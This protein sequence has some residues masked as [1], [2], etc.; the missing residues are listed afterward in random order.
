MGGVEEDF[1]NFPNSVKN[2]VFSHFFPFW[3]LPLIRSLQRITKWCE[4]SILA[5]VSRSIMI[6]TSPEPLIFAHSSLFYNLRFQTLH[7]LWSKQ[8][9]L[10][11]TSIVDNWVCI[12]NRKNYA[13]EIKILFV[14][15]TKFPIVKN[16]KKLLL[17]RHLPDSKN[18]ENGLPIHCSRMHRIYGTQRFLSSDRWV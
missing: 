7:I 6:C 1:K 5:T 10:F 15:D 8:L 2:V 12:Y 4:G 17:Y 14:K 16:M 13:S 9:S 18:L 11:E 3:F